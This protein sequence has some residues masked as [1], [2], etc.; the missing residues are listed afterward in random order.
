MRRLLLS[1][2]VLFAAAAL[3]VAAEPTEIKLS[4]FKVKAKNEG[5][6]ADLYGY[7]EGEGKI[8]MYVL[9]TAT[10]EF[11]VKEDG[12]YK[13]AIEA[14]GDEGKGKAQFRLSI[15]GKEVEKAFALKQNEAKGYEFKADLKKGKQ[16]IEIEFLND[17]YKEGEY[18]CNLYVHSVKF[19]K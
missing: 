9:A 17:E 3:A 2:A 15:G 19:E 8:F 11:E 4:Q 10:A 18:D 7:N 14:S 1:V 16:T 6:G 12:A 13:F 5:T